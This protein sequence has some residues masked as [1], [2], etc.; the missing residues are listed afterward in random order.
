MVA[1]DDHLLEGGNGAAG[2]GSQLGQGAVVVQ[3]QHAVVVAGVGAANLLG[4]GSG[5]VGV[6]V[7]G[8][9]H[10]QDLHVFLGVFSDG[11]ALNG[12]DGTVG[13]Q[14]VGTL[15]ALAA[16][17]GAHQQTDVGVL[18]GD[19]GV[20]GGNH[21]GQQRESTVFQ[22][23]HHALDGLLG[24]RQIEQLQ[25]DGLVFA[26]HFAGGDAEEQAVADLAGGAGNGYAHGGFGHG[27]TPVSTV[28]EQNS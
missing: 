28:V 19:V 12:E 17:T 15:H 26:E 20:V 8:V 2:L 22:F 10:H 11:L 18:E 25:N 16:G 14:Q 4:G 3:A 9:A 23:H 5:D 13:G 21:A 1:P 6:G 7:A 24:L 27:A